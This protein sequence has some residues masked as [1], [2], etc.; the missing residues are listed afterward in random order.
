MDSYGTV[1]IDEN[2][3]GKLILEEQLWKWTRCI[4]QNL[5]QSEDLM[6]VWVYMESGKWLRSSASVTLI[7]TNACPRN[8]EEEFSMKIQVV[9]EM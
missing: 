9:I 6:A 8:K 5:G 3:V 1:N 2:K 7:K 4:S